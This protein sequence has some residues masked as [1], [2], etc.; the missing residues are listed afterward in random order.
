GNLNNKRDCCSAVRDGCLKAANLLNF[1]LS[2]VLCTSDSRKRSGASDLR[3]PNSMG[4]ISLETTL[5][6]ARRAATRLARMSRHL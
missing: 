4:C 6:E 5:L 2:D 1:P 3:R